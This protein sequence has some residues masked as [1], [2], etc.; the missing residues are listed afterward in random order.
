MAPDPVT[1]LPKPK[2]FRPEAELV[3]DERQPGVYL[4]L[5][6]ARVVYVGQTSHL[7]LRLL[8]HRNE[9]RK[10][11]DAALFYHM[12]DS[13]ES[14]R[15]WVEGALICLYRPYANKGW[16]VGFS[17]GRCWEIG[18]GRRGRKA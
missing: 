6:E 7:M 12:P 10:Q 1:K 17:A 3:E 11:F 5:Q 14:D 18:F 9:G 15:L 13:N 2:D 4:L 8:Q 16:H